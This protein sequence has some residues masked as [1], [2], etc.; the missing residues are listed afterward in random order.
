MHHS[1][2]YSI[3]VTIQSIN[4][5]FYP[6]SYAVAENKNKILKVEN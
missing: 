4:T 5:H 3:Q 1:Y 2:L 6:K